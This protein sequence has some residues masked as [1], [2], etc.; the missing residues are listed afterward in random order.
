[1][2]SLKLAVLALLLLAA[3]AFAT[4]V[5]IS[6]VGQQWTNY[7]NGIVDVNGVPTAMPGIGAQVRFKVTGLVYD[8]SIN[9]TLLSLD[10][11]V[12]NTSDSS[13]WQ[14]A[15]VSGIA[16]DTNP[17]VTRVGSG[18]SGAY[19]FVALNQQL[20]TGAGFV[21][22]VCVSGRLNRCNGPL[23]GA[24]QIGQIGVA[25]VTLGFRGDITG[26]PITLDNFAVRYVDLFSTSL[27]VN[28]FGGIGL[29]VTPPIPEPASAAAFGIGA[30]IVGAALRRMRKN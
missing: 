5:T 18:A 4:S 16:F 8:A 7:Y 26:F 13:I 10:V 14:M 25:A 11:V 3:P 15:T 24:T 9:R 20:P 12:K 1:M 29:P 27:G 6:G 30:L 19:G 2:K 21:V 22:E 23:Q 17:N 28:G